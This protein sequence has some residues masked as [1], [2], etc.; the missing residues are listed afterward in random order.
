MGRS[1]HVCASPNRTEYDKL[2]ING[3]QIKEI[4]KLAHQKYN[5]THLSYASFQGHFA[6]DVEMLIDSQVKASKLREQ[7]VKENIKK[8]IEIAR[9]LTNNLEIISDKIEEYAEK[10]NVTIDDLEVLIKLINQSS[11]IIEL[12]LKWSAKLDI[13]VDDMD[14]FS[15]IM[16]CIEDFPP[17]LVAKFAERWKDFGK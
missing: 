11:S 16:K 8:D 5:E 2:R 1:C 15:K 12:F 10:E 7:V 3:M 17:D 4:W 14:T 9:R 13:K 6:N